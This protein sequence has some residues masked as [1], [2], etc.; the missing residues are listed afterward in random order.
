M[1]ARLSTLRK[2]SPTPPKRKSS[3][4]KRS[5]SPK[6]KEGRELLAL[7]VRR[8]SELRELPKGGRRNRR[9]SSHRRRF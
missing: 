4:R 5:L 1:E 8:A 6:T 9:R 2:R 3:I 7:K